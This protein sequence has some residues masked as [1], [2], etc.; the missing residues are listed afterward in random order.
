MLYKSL[1]IVTGVVGYMVSKFYYNKYNCL[2][3]EFRLYKDNQDKK[4]YNYRIE[5]NLINQV[6]NNKLKLKMEK[7]LEEKM[8]FSGNYSSDWYLS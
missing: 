3:K 7:D 6:N 2:L 8:E 1:F 5:L 4:F